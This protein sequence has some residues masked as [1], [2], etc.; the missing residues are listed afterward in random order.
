MQYL[1]NKYF[2]KWCKKE[3]INTKELN[4]II[5]DF[6]DKKS[7]SSLGK[8][9]FKIRVANDGKGKSGSKRSILF[10]KEKEKLIFCLGFSKNEKSNI[11]SSDKKIL[12]YLATEYNKLTKNDLITLV[13][14]KVLFKINRKLL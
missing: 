5:D 1:M 9:L 6:M 13:K 7:V 4:K 8:M 14:K 2:K 12:N 10:F 11:D 3:N